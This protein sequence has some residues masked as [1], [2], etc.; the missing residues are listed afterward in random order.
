MRH[1]RTQRC[2]AAG[3]IVEASLRKRKQWSK[4]FLTISTHR[5]S[6]LP[7]CIKNTRCFWAHANL[8]ER[9][10][11]ENGATAF[12]QET[13]DGEATSRDGCSLH[14][15]TGPTPINKNSAPFLVTK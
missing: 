7:L 5:S 10:P 1:P 11:P 12:T 6:S 14:S 2:L 4:F 15:P 8:D 3:S 13:P 9:T